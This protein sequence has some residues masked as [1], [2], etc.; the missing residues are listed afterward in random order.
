MI[1]QKEKKKKA[2]AEKNAEEAKLKAE[3]KKAEQDQIAQD[4]ADRLQQ[5]K[6]AGDPESKLLVWIKDPPFKCE[7]TEIKVSQVCAVESS[8]TLICRYM[9]ISFI[10]S[11]E[12][13]NG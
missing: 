8:S 6:Q 9:L 4:I 10:E 1:S 11:I 7:N 2:K 3:A 13:S 12:V 5:S